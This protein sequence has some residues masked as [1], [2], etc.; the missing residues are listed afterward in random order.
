[1]LKSIARAENESRMPCQTK[2]SDSGAPST[3]GYGV[4]VGMDWGKWNTDV[5]TS[6]TEAACPGASRQA[7]AI[8]QELI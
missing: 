1:M 5:L 4:T 7:V 3:Y 6:W 2:Q 8:T